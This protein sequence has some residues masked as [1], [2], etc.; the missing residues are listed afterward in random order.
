MAGLAGV[1]ALALLFGSIQRDAADGSLGLFLDLLFGLGGTVP[2][3][4]DEATLLDLLLELVPSV[5]LESHL[6]A[7]TQ[8]LGVDVLLDFF[9]QVL[10]TVLDTGELWR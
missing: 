10:D 3:C 8:G 4:Q 5:D 2:M 6:L 1:D 7:M 9:E